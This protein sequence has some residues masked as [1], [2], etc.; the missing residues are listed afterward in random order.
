MPS[1][2]LSPR[3]SWAARA[4]PI[5]C[6]WLA[7]AQTMQVGLQVRIWVNWLV[8]MTREIKIL[9]RPYLYLEEK[10]NQERAMNA[11]SDLLDNDKPV[12]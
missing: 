3:S 7:Y 2:S 1:T 6:R 8:Q 10:V 9:K 12:E 11:E 5:Q 4:L